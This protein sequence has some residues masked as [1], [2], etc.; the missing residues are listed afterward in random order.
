MSGR[1][2]HGAAP[3]RRAARGA[4]V[5]LRPRAGA[6]QHGARDRPLRA[7]RVRRRRERRA[8][9]PSVRPGRRR[10]A[11]VPRRAP[12]GRGGR[13]EGGRVRHPRHPADAPRDG[14][15][16]P[17]DVR[18]ARREEGDFFEW[19]RAGGS[20]GRASCSGSSRS[21]TW[22]APPSSSPPAASSGTPESSCSGR[23]YLLEELASA[24]SGG[25][26][27][28]PPRIRRSSER[29][30]HHLQRIFLFF[31]LHIDRRRRHGEG[32]PRSH[33]PVSLR[34]ERPRVLGS[35]VRVPRRQGPAR[36]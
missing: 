10:R 20:G 24:P 16:L 35:R 17:G 33:D 7:R 32:A 18:R 22:Q 29:R 28:G 30:S 34:L 4:R 23:H 11:R 26:R 14:V 21:R 3:P 6:P 2:S 13:R 19:K 8:A 36:T 1:E 25:P 5:P 31:P 12:R 27:R 15:R 9:R